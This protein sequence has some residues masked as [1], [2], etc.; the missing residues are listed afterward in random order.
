MAAA[1]CDWCG[2]CPPRGTHPVR[3]IVAGVATHSVQLCRGCLDP[4]LVKIDG[5]FAA[6]DLQTTG[7]GV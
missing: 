6:Q 4:L 5:A 1:V 7:G 3:V 2:F